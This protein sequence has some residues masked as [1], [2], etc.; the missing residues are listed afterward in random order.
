M[1]SATRASRRGG[2][3]L[4]RLP[5]AVVVAVAIAPASLLAT[6]LARPIGVFIEGG[7]ATDARSAVAGVAWTWLLPA[8]WGDGHASGYVET[9]IGEWACRREIG[10]SYRHCSTQFGVT[11]V[12]R[13]QPSSWTHWFVELGIGADVITPAFRSNERRFRTEYNFGDHVGLGRSFGMDG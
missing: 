9:S 4:A 6:E 10:G 13:W 11:P 12:I 1:S 3:A 7:A 5:L 2:Q 8:R